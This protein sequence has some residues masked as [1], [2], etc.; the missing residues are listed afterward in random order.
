MLRR[1]FIKQLAVAAVPPALLTRSKDEEKKRRR[2]LIVDRVDHFRDQHGAHQ[3]VVRLRPRG[4]RE[5]RRLREWFNDLQ[6]RK[7]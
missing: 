5:K 3:I 4:Q 7:R 1:G 2:P 6:I